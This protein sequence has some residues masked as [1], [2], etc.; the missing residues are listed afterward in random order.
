MEAMI[1]PPTP[2]DTA[3][4]LNAIE[5]ICPTPAGRFLIFRMITTRPHTKYRTAINGTIFSQTLP[6]LL[7]PPNSTISANTVSST[8]VTAFGTP[9]V[10]FRA[11]EIELACVMFP[12]PKEAI[13]ANSAKATAKILPRTGIG[14]A[15]FITY[16]GPPAISPSWLTSRYLTAKRLSAYFVD[17]PNNAL[18]HIHTSAPGPPK[19]IAVATPTMFPVPIVAARA[20]I[21]DWNGVISPSCCSSVLSGL[22]NTDFSAYPRFLQGRNFSR[23]VKNTPVPTRSTNMI[24]PQTKSLTLCKISSN[25]F[26]LQLL[27]LFYV[28]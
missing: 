14:N 22:R 16:M 27:P 6:I 12:I 11:S 19:T 13:T 20:V 1:A 18:S 4:T 9:K 3:F 28:E 21:R 23:M 15:F 8:P 5:K 17:R 24:G 2:P 26:I 7:I 10:V 25:N